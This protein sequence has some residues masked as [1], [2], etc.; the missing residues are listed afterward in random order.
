MSQLSGVPLPLIIASKSTQPDHVAESITSCNSGDSNTQSLLEGANLCDAREKAKKARVGSR[1]AGPWTVGSL[2]DDDSDFDFVDEKDRVSRS[3]RRRRSTRE[4]RWHRIRR[5]TRRR[6]VV[7]SLLHVTCVIG[8][9]VAAGVTGGMC[10]SYV[11]VVR[12]GGAPVAAI[13]VTR[14]ARHGRFTIHMLRS[15]NHHPISLTQKNLSQNPV[16]R[17]SGRVGIGILELK[18]LVSVSP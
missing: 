3:I 18:K 12:R 15:P 11:L 7:A 2:F 10:G 1:H 16:Y 13:A 8:C 4:R 17:M 9:T 5:T 14:E 6:E